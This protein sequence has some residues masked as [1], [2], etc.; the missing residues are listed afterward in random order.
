[1]FGKFLGAGPKIAKLPSLAQCLFWHNAFCHLF[2]LL[3]HQT[4]GAAQENAGGNVR[5][6]LLGI[7]K[8]E[9]YSQTF[10]VSRR[11]LAWALGTFFT[12]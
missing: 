7:G 2:L 4:A 6:K 5:K 9:D 1:M 12:T 10:R 11:I 8:P 3:L